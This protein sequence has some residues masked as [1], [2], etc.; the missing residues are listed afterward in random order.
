MQHHGGS[1]SGSVAIEGLVRKPHPLPASQ[2]RHLHRI[3]PETEV[4]HRQLWAP[5]CQPDLTVAANR[6][7]PTVLRNRQQSDRTLW[8]ETLAKVEKQSLSWL[9]GM[10]VVDARSANKPSC[11]ALIL[12]SMP[13]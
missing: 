4:R 6:R 2:R 5:L 13:P 11:C 12:C 3:D 8:S 9:T 10:A 7:I 1:E